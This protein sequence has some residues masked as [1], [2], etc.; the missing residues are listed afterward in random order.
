M[1]YFK[2]K[3]IELFGLPKTG[4][5]TTANA[6]CKYL[7]TKGYKVEIVKERASLS[8]LKNKLHP[9]FNYWT[10]IS[11]IKE[12][13]EANDKSVDYLIA[14]RGI[15]D[16]YVWINLLSKKENEP[17][18]FAEFEKLAKQDIVLSNYFLTFYFYTTVEK[19]LEREIERHINYSAGRIMNK[20]TLNEYLDSY[21]EVQNTLQKITTIVEIETTSL[22]IPGVLD[23]ISKRIEDS[24]NR[25]EK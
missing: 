15:F 9:S 14:D 19:S 16:S 25:R 13:I 1:N 4:K 7:R 11:F 23:F 22:T 12:F 2:T 18:F 5:T 24:I 3:I 20:V 6:L 10:T 21:K 8:P 17:K